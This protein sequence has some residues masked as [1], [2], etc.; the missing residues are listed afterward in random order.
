M[1]IEA[2]RLRSALGKLNVARSQIEGVR[3]G[4]IKTPTA[5][6]E[7]EA[8]LAEAA[9][10]LQE[11][12]KLVEQG[13]TPSLLITE[14]NGVTVFQGTLPH[15]QPDAQQAPGE[16]VSTSAVEWASQAVAGQ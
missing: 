1:A 11:E 3:T 15:G 16:Q 9:A 8:M 6:Q 2:K 13:R 10:I 7:A 12:A 4:L 5:Q 14:G